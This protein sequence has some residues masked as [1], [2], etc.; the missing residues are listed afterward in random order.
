MTDELEAPQEGVEVVQTEAEQAE[1][2]EAP[3]STEG[4]TQEATAEEDAEAKAKAEAE[5][6]EQRKSR[7]QRRREA[8]ERSERERQEALTRADEA[9]KRQREQA[10]AA[11][12]LPVPKESDFATL[13]EHQAALARYAAASALSDAEA[14]QLQADAERNRARAEQIKHEQA[15]AVQDAWRDHLSD[16]YAKYP[17]L[18]TDVQAG[19]FMFTSEM[20]QMT[21]DSDVAPEVVRYLQKNPQD[22]VAI[23]QMDPVSMARALG[24]IEALV[25][26]PKPKT[27]TSAPEPITPLKGKAAHKSP[28]EMTPAEYSAWREAGGTF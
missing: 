13:D 24:R 28:G 8:R 21:A 20:M 25:S 27:T 11:K 22:S 2:A 9:E 16:A 18:Q 3:E 1:A 5:E 23:G 17:D 10:E 4:Q 6:E 12:S 14:K 19:T 15:L 7:S 26:A